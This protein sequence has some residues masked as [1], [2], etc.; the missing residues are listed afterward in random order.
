[1]AQLK[2]ALLSNARLHRADL[3]HAELQGAGLQQVDLQDGDLRWA[4]LRGTNLY[5]AR[6]F[7]KARWYRALLDRTRM[8]RDQLGHAIGDEVE[9]HEEKAPQAYHHAAE[10]YLLLKNNFNS[11]GRYEDAAW[12]S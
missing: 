6:S 11:I 5:G 10:A 3:H 4:Q 7:P 8:R 9:A 2:R 12:A 1:M